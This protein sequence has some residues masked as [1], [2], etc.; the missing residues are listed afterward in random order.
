MAFAF[1]P[2]ARKQ[3]YL[4]LAIQG[5]SGGGKTYAALTLAQM[6]GKRIAAID[7]ERGSLAKCAAAYDAQ[8][9]PVADGGVLDERNVSAF[10]EAI[11]AAGAAG[12]EVLIVDSYSHSWLGALEQVDAIGG[13]KFT[14]GWKVISPLVTKLVDTILSYPGHVIV[15][16]RSK[17]EYVIEQN[18]KGKSEPRK[19]GLAAVAREGQEYEFDVVLDLD[20]S[21]NVN[22]A[23]SR[24]PGLSPGSLLRRGEPGTKEIGDWPKVA[25][26][27][28]SWLETGAEPTPAEKLIERLKFANDA[29]TLA[30]LGKEIADLKTA[31][32]LTTEDLALIGK[33]Y[34]SRKAE[35]EAANADPLDG[36]S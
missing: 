34:L 36:V 16:M 11:Q 5:V 8:G 15:T 4:R 21:G 29:T 3:A 19:I 18:A 26:A 32:S 28:K 23:K 31:G 12:Y 14:G 30:A 22:V 24:C 6:F 17:S 25:D 13:N 20:T 33:A 10:I 7:S 9:R 35:N 2:L 1:K 27:I